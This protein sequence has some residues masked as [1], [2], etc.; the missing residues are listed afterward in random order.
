MSNFVVQFYKGKEGRNVGLSTGIPPLDK[1]INGIQKKQIIGLAAAE[2]V[3]KTKLCNYAFIIMP[4]LIS[5]L[6]QGKKVRWKYFSFEVDRISMEFE[7]A[8][9]FL[10]YDFGIDSFQYNGKIYKISASYLQGKMLDENDNPIIVSQSHEE[11]I[12]KIYR[13]RI[14]PLFGE[15]NANGNRVSEGLI[16]FIGEP[17]NP[18]GLYNYMLHFADKNGTWITENYITK[19]DSG[20]EVSRER[21]I[22]YTPNDPDEWIIIITDHM[23]KLRRERNFD[24]KENIDKWLEYQVWLRNK[25]GYTFIDIIHLNRAISAIE[26]LKFNAEFLHP[27]SD[28]LKDSGNV[29]EEANILL[30]M[31]DPNDEKYG[32]RKH[33]GLELFENKRVKYPYYKSLHLVSSRDS[34]SHVHIQLN[35]YGH[36]G[37]FEQLVI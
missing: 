13:Q 14:V 26:R 35:M 18:T 2:K 25:C 30:T 19:D 37:R 1:A 3:G 12:K 23:R 32:L 8:T 22:G 11:L 16:D 9:F 29:G 31:F 28:D 7:F 21:R 27:T 10:Y 24:R 6:K 33:F 36:T 5:V 4:Y 17:E 34:Q 15:F 20:R